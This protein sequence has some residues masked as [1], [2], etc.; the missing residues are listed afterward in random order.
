VKQLGGTEMKRL[1]REWRRKPNGRLSLLLEGIASPWNLGA[2]IRT[3]AAYRVDHIWIAASQITPET[4]NVGKVALG[5][6]R[7]V[8]WTSVGTV[9][10]AVKG[11]RAAGERL[12]GLELADHATPMH[13]STLDN[14]CLAIGHED[15]GLSKGLLAECDAVVFLPQMGKIGSLN[16]ATAT[17]IA[18]YEVRRQSWD[19]SD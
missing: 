4:T 3:A 8:P 1:H 15:R 14:V 12:V 17:S 2:L 9:E 16:L 11:I 7:Y 18:L 10:E 13:E 19:R 6:D 5:T